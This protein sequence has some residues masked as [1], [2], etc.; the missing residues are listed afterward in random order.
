MTDVYALRTA[1]GVHN[2]ASGTF[3]GEDEAATIYLGFVP[4]YVKVFNVTAETVWEKTNDMAAGACFSIAPVVVNVDE[5]ASL[6]TV[7]TGITINSNGTITLA[8]EVVGDGD[9]VSWIA[10][11]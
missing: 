1:G 11:A 10:Q 9:T 6:G 2:F 5:D 7:T 3:E 4:Q 8:A